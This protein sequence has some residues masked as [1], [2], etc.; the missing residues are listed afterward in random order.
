MSNETRVP[1]TQPEKTKA[2]LFAE[3]PD[4]FQDMHDVAFAIIRHPE[5]GILGHCIKIGK[6]GD[7]ITDV[8][9]EALKLQSFADRKISA[10]LD[11]IDIEIAS[12]NKATSIVKPNGKQPFYKFGRN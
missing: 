12:R 10:F 5:N 6:E 9:E 8:Y 7:R 3:D 2:E 11:H 4:R 1:E